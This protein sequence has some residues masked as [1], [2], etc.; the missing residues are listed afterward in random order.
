MVVLLQGKVQMK[1]GLASSV[2]GKKPPQCR[3]SGEKE[4]HF[5]GAFSPRGAAYGPESRQLPLSGGWGGV[6][7]RTPPNAEN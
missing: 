1:A 4:G 5:P 7:G 6:G 3:P 2:S